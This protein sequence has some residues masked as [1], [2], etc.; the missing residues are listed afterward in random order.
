MELTL[1]SAF[2]VG[3]MVGH[4]AYV[5]LVLSMLMHSIVAL[6]IFFVVNVLLSIFYFTV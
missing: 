4:L 6:R 5:F 3:G 2:F 1:N